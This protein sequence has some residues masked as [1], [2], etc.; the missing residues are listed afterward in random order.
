[1]E[2]ES[3]LTCSWTGMEFPAERLRTVIC[4]SIIPVVLYVE[5]LN[6]V[7]VDYWTPFNPSNKFPR[8]SY[9]ADPAYLSA[10][11]IQDASYIRL[12]TLQ[13]G[14]TFPTRLLKNTPIHK[15]RL[16]ATATNLLTFTEFKS[17]SPRTDSRV[18]SGVQTICVWCQCFILK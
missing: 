17:Y 1:M 7:K 8:P 16:Y 9:S 12:R 5:K 2:L 15:L 13:L 18:L 11:A 10:I 6:G 3:D 4:T 14:Y